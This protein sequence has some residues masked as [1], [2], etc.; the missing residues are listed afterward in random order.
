[1]Y[2]YEDTRDVLWDIYFPYLASFN[3]RR[4]KLIKTM[5]MLV[6]ESMSRWHPKTTMLGGLPNYM[7]KPRNQF[8]LELCLEM[9]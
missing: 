6:D 7:F 9:V 4:Q 8:H 5:I 3:D 2:W 1:M